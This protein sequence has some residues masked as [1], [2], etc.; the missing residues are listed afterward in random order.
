[1]ALQPGQIVHVTRALDEFDLPLWRLRDLPFAHRNEAARRHISC[2]ELRLSEI[3]STQQ[4][5]RLKQIVWQ[6][7]GVDAVL[8]QKLAAKLKLSAQQTRNISA[9]LNLAYKKLAELQKRTHTRSEASQALHL[10]KLRTNTQENIMAVLGPSQQQMFTTLMGER[11]ALPQ[12]RSI[13]CKAPELE[14]NTWINASPLKLS[15]MRGKVTVV[16]FYAFGCGNCVRTLPHFNAWQRRFADRGLRIIGIH[17][18]ETEQERDL[19]KVKEKAAEANMLY[20]I[21]ID[22]DSRAW[23]AWANTVWPSIYLIDKDGYIRYWWYGEVN[24]QG[25]ESELFLRGKIQALI[26]EAQSEKQNARTGDISKA[27]D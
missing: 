12:V 25:V 24:W 18:P 10:Q 8:E 23:N 20:P 7:L 11:F 14:L 2:L 4:L 16:H 15:E 17:R 26:R 21:A 13:A 27:P 22:N 6:A 19:Q 3:L 5:E 1:L 9:F